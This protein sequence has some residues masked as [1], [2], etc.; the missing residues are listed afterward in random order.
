[1]A[2][3]SIFGTPLTLPPDRFAGQTDFGAALARYEAE[4]KVRIL[5]DNGAGTP[6]GAPEPGFEASFPTWPPPGV[7]ATTWYLR[8]GG[9]LDR[10]PPPAGDHG[11][12]AYRYDPGSVPS[13]DATPQTI[14][15]IWTTQPP[16]SWQPPRAGA[17]LTYTSDR[18]PSDVVLTG[19]ASV[20]LWLRTSAPDS[21]LEVALTEVRPDGQETYVQSGWL[22]ASHRTSLRPDSTLLEPRYGDERS[23]VHPMPKGQY[24]LVR[25]PLFPVVHPFR[26]GSRL[27]IVVQAPGGNRPLWAFQDLPG[28]ARNEVARS[29][30]LASR[31]VLPV[32]P[33]VAV[34]TPLPPCPS[35][36]GEPCRAASPPA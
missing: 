5:F 27:R 1:V 17:A 30:T 10:A 31:I 21:D 28:P 12:D 32:N 8:S 15:L 11:A 36:R 29:A 35:L 14:N 20:D 7:Q 23:Q 2:Y 9:R 26:A 16:Y 13:T 33:A 25:V 22:R 19:P 18:L 4:P 3:T 34:P 24:A 6:A